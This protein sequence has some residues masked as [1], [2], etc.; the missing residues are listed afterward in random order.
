MLR[1]LT[2]L[3]AALV[4]A[5]PAAHARDADDEDEDQGR[6]PGSTADFSTAPRVDVHKPVHLIPLYMRD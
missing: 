2:L 5:L 4:L 1:K 3:A 6:G